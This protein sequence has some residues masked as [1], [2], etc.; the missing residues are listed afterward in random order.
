MPEFTTVFEIT[1]NSNGVFGDEVFRL[2]IGIVALLGS[3]TLLVRNVRRRESAKDYIGP[4]FVLIWSVAW[5]S[6]HLLPNVFG[7]VNKLVSAYRDKRY[8]IV[9]G[10]V[11][12]LWQ[13]PYHG[14]SQGDRIRVNGKE[15]VVNYFYATPA[16]TKTIAH[17]GVL[18]QGTYARIYYYEGEILRV[19]IRR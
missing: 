13:Q 16:Y 12:V 7:H 18:T 14:H 2:L 15:F 19:D 6:M 1:R 8:E 4:V 9:E 5:I 11:Q 10:P 17:G 3:L